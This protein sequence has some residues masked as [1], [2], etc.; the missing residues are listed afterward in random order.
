MYY[1]SIQDKNNQLRFLSSV[2]C[3]GK[4]GGI[5]DQLLTALE[6]I[7]TVPNLDIISR[8]IWQGVIQPAKVAIGIGWRE[9]SA[10]LDTS[11]SGTSLFKAN[12]SRERLNRINRVLENKTLENLSKSDVYWDEIISIQPVGV[13]NVY[14]ATIMNHHNFIANDIIVHNSIEQDADVVLFIYRK[15]RDKSSVAPEEENIAEIIISKHRNGPLGT[16]RLRFDPE[17]AS[18]KNIDTYHQGPA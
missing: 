18:F 17:K 9:F 16:A 6:K 10:K 8:E 4:R 1:V 12:I 5:I 15:D 13:D 14:D 2:G 11:Y 3:H 7:Q